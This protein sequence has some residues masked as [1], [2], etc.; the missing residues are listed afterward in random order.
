MRF[1]NNDH[2]AEACG[3]DMD[4][5][6]LKAYAIS[7][8]KRQEERPNTSKKKNALFFHL[9]YFSFSPESEGG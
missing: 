9:H 4:I 3:K 1:K 7:E 5:Q 6:E 2:V 8:D